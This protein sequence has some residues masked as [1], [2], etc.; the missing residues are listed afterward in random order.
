MTST[1][2]VLIP[3]LSTLTAPAED[4]Q[5]LA[6]F[7]R[8]VVADGGSGVQQTAAEE[9]VRD[10]GLILGRPLEKVRLADLKGVAPGLSFFVGDAAARVALGSLPGPWKADEWF[11]RTVA[12]GLVLAGQDGPGQSLGGRPEWFALVGGRR[13]PLQMCTTNPEVITQVVERVLHSP[14]DIVN[15]SPSAGGG[16]CECGDCVK[17][18]VPGSL[19]NFRRLLKL[20][21]C[22]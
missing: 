14:L 9:L 4:V 22:L 8:V 11:L 12:R 1:L 16:F 18:D 21:S 17:L 5:K 6:D 2:L 15:I 19:K 3:L 20:R 10:V 13:R 7:R